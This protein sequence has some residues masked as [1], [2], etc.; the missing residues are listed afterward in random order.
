MVDALQRIRENVPNDADAE[1]H[2]SPIIT[3]VN[4]PLSVQRSISG[5]APGVS[6]RL[7]GARC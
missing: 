1:C 6:G 2:A 7:H 4:Q 5:R 3:G